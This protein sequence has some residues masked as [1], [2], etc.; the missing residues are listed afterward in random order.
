[1]PSFELHH[2]PVVLLVEQDL[3]YAAT[4]SDQLQAYFE[5]VECE[6]GGEALHA[7]ELEPPDAIVIDL[8]LPDMEGETLAETVRRQWSAELPIVMISSGASQAGLCSDAAQPVSEMPCQ[9]ESLL[10]LLTS[11]TH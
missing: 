11:I 7:L 10:A 6:S 5:V 9:T 1:M 2:R 4:L 8:D 3:L